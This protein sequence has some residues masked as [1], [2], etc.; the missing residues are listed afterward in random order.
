MFWDQFKAE[1]KKIV[2]AKKSLIVLGLEATG[3]L[4]WSE[5]QKPD[6]VK[7]RAFAEENITEH[8]SVIISPVRGGYWESNPDCRYHKPEC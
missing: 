8:Q 2:E 7:N 1:E 3:A 6:P 4:M 5:M